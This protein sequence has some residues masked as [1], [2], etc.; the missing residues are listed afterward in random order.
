MKWKPLKIRRK[1]TQIH[2]EYWKTTEMR[3]YDQFLF[4]LHNMKKQKKN[5]EFRLHILT[6]N[7]FR[8]KELTVLIRNSSV[9][10]CLMA[11]R[12]CHLFRFCLFSY[13]SFRIATGAV[14]FSLNSKLILKT[15][16]EWL[17][18]ELHEVQFSHFIWIANR[19]LYH[20]IVCY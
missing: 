1:I 20:I 5:N 2:W 6:M 4:F 16:R 3:Q 11:G 7:T 17:L 10:C 13:F 12:I 14:W 15:D 18:Y 9:V 8:C 19:R